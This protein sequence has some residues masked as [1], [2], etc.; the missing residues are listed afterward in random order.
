MG[1]RGRG[2]G[3]IGIH[4]GAALY[5]PLSGPNGGAL[6]ARLKKSDAVDRAQVRSVLPALGAFTVIEDM[7]KR[8][9]S[10]HL[11][12]LGGDFLGKGL[13]KLFLTVAAP[14]AEGAGFELSSLSTSR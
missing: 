6:L 13:S 2:R 14:F 9:V 12:D 8:G 4:L 11:L 7:R 10:L 1:L 3:N 5:P